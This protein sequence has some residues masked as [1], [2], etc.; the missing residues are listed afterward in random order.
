M[1]LSFKCFIFI[2]LPLYIYL[3][4]IVPLQL[5]HLSLPTIIHNVVLTLTIERWSAQGQRGL[6]DDVWI[7]TAERHQVVCP[8][9]YIIFVVDVVFNILLFTY[10]IIHQASMI[11]FV[12]NIIYTCVYMNLSPQ[13]ILFA[14]D[15][16]N[17]CSL[18]PPQRSHT[19]NRGRNLFYRPRASV[20]PIIPEQQQLSFHRSHAYLPPINEE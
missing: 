12:N 19:D 11:T 16:Q 1:N 17:Y 6:S 2:L 14:S 20:S 7:R 18:S 10:I 13:A 5:N 9:T 15:Q 8:R 3:Q 4:V